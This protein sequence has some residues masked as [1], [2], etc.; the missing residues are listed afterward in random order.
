MKTSLILIAVSLSLGAIYT[1][2]ALFVIMLP[3]VAVMALFLLKPSK[4]AAKMAV[5][6]LSRADVP[7]LLIEFLFSPPFLITAAVIIFYLGLACVANLLDATT[8]AIILPSAVLVGLIVAAGLKKGLVPQPISTERMSVI[9]FGL[10][11][12]ILVFKLYWMNFYWGDP[13]SLQADFISRVLAWSCSLSFDSMLTFIS[14]FPLLFLANLW[15]FRNDRRFSRASKISISLAVSV[16]SGMITCSFL[17]IAWIYLSGHPFGQVPVETKCIA[18]EAIRMTVALSTV[19][20]S[21]SGLL[22]AF[23]QIEAVG[24]GILTAPPRPAHIPMPLLR[25]SYTLAFIGAFLIVF[26]GTFIH[27]HQ[28]QIHEIRGMCCTI[29]GRYNDAFSAFDEALRLE[30]NY[31]DVYLERAYTLSKVGRLEEATRDLGC[32]LDLN[33]SGF[34]IESVIGRCFELRRPELVVPVC[35]KI[36]AKFPEHVDA[37]LHRGIALA[38]LGDQEKARA[39]FDRVIA[40]YPNYA[41]AYVCRS[42]LFQRF[43]KLESAFED[44]TIAV[45]M[46][47]K[48]AMAYKTRGS[49][50][51][52]MECPQFALN[53]LNLSIKFD[54]SEGTAYHL[55]S[56]I[57]NKLGMKNDAIRDRTRALELGLE[58]GTSE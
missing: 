35:D 33:V 47:P 18:R 23:S 52:D 48:N 43:G 38:K 20:F 53:D 7:A 37:H 4:S 14:V 2:P 10:A 26:F 45:A 19:G 5:P 39:S 55:R 13:A 32:G 12:N 9:L 17:P 46:E 6:V 27:S 11:L 16:L 44:A 31:G 24:I 50:L 56:K 57:E 30:P 28:P 15:L 40:L 22:I 8:V 29:A 1:Q 41:Y 36:I 51:L 34:Q 25:P 58:S 42:Y 49:V 54:P 21:L 3:F